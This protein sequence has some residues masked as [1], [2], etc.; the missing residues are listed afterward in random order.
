MYIDIWSQAP[1]RV[2][3]YEIH[4]TDEADL[5]TDQV[6]KYLPRARGVELRVKNTWHIK[7]KF[8]RKFQTGIKVYIYL[9]LYVF[10]IFPI[11]ESFV[12]VLYCIVCLRIFDVSL[13][14]NIS[15]CWKGNKWGEETS[16]MY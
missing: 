8:D 1:V 16:G 12:H 14:E 15:V 5:S 6:S 7:G 3:T 9:T 2:Y 13:M 10:L 4:N 11:K